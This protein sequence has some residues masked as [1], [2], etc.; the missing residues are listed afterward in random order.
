VP[1]RVPR[2][3][4]LSVCLV[5]RLECAS[6]VSSQS[7]SDRR[8]GRREMV[9]LGATVASVVIALVAW[10]FPCAADVPPPVPTPA[11]VPVSMPDGEALPDAPPV[12]PCP[13]MQ[14]SS[15]AVGTI[16]P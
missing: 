13:R 16:G 1:A 3:P 6:R 14:P 11:S 12:R 8:T 5:V 4:V 9:M 10:L 15:S 2:D 7:E